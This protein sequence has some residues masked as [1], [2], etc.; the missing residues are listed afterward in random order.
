MIGKRAGHL[1]FWRILP[2]VALGTAVPACSGS[3]DDLPRQP[4]AGRVFLDGKPLSH[5]T[6]MFYPEELSTKEHERVSSGD[7]IVNGWFS[8]PREKGL[9]PGLYKIAVTS[10]KLAKHPSRTDREDSP[11]EVHAPAEEAIPKRF[12]ASSVL[13]IEIKQGGIKELRIDLQST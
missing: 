2:L 3:S 6:I 10:E 7:S 4:V 13:D 12:N 5:G 1:R 9:V 11:G 8:I